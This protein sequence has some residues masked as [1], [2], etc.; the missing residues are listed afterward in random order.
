MMI[1]WHTFKADLTF[2]ILMILKQLTGSKMYYF[3][4]HFSFIVHILQPKLIAQI[5]LEINPKVSGIA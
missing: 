3:A 2:D 4:N 5:F 1:N